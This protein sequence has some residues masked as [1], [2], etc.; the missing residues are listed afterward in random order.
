MAA[1]GQQQRGRS[2]EFP[3]DKVIRA[4]AQLAPGDELRPGFEKLVK[5]MGVSGA[6]VVRIALQDLIERQLTGTTEEAAA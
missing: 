1:L 6:Q 2:G 3:P 5:S 4:V